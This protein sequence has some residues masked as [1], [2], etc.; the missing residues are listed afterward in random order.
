KTSGSTGLHIYLYLHAKYTYDIARDFIQLITE[1]VH[2]E[3][4]DT[5]SLVRDP[6]KRKGRIYLDYLQNR[7]G[8]TVVAPYSL[9][10]KPYAPVSTPLHWEEVRKGLKITDHTL[11]TIGERM[12]RVDDPWAKIFDHP[13]DLKQAL[14]KL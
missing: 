14:G 9:R 13:A 1:M 4:P 12:R 7:R 2:D 3:H 6:K 5:T 11:L 10:P 8:Q